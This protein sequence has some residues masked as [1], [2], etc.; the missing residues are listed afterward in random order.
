MEG[1]PCARAYGFPW[2]DATSLVFFSARGQEGSQASRGGRAPRRTERS[3][4]G[5]VPPRH[6]RVVGTLSMPGHL[7]VVKG[8]NPVTRML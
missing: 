4:L 8:L 1:L 2:G 7:D 3:P 5:A 6:R